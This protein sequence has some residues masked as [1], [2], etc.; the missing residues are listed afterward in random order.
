MPSKKTD[1]AKLIAEM[2]GGPPWFSTPVVIDA[3]TNGETLKRRAIVLD[4]DGKEVTVDK[5]AKVM[6]PDDATPLVARLVK[7]SGALDILRRVGS[8]LL[9]FGP[10][11]AT[12][13][14]LKIPAEVL[15]VLEGLKKSKSAEDR[16]LAT[17]APLAAEHAWARAAL[18]KIAAM[19]K[20][21]KATIEELIGI[22]ETMRQVG[23][24]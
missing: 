22:F 20:D 23:E 21:G 11:L 10:R 15:G 8:A 2:R 16:Y 17:L 19:F 3:F 14:G 24:G 6:L 13:A 9:N 12:V 4:D 18:P 5:Y 1:H 7:T